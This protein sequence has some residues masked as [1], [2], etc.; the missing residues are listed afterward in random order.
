MRWEDFSVFDF[1]NQFI[2]V[3]VPDADNRPI[4]AF[5][6]KI[7]SDRLGKTRDEIVGQPAHEIFSGRAAYSVYRRQCGAW[8]NGVETDYEIALPLGTETMWARTN[9]V[10][11]HDANGQVTHMIG[12]TQDITD[13]RK[14]LQD[15]VLSAAA[16]QDLEDLMCMA[17]HDLRSPLS[18][19]KTL[20]GMMR[21]DF[22]DHGD[23]KSQL[24][25]M[26]D[27][28]SD[29]AL[30]VVSSIMGQAMAM[31]PVG[32]NAAFDLGAM[33]DDVMVMLDPISKH[34]VSYPRVEVQAEI[35]VVHIVLR[36]LI[37]NAVKHSGKEVVKI[38]IDMTPMNAER[39]LFRVSDNGSGF[40]SRVVDAW[41]TAESGNYGGFGLMGVRRLVRSRGGNVALTT[42][43]S[44]QGAEVQVE[45]PGRIVQTRA[46][47]IASLRAG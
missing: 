29:R 3:L 6:N 10:P 15:H 27:S 16:A 18:N 47:P 39:L 46:A 4:Y 7:G 40:D 43:T 21:K 2:F 13:E 38:S 35:M 32:C 33:C 34:S 31:G 9:L 8:A 41:E 19:L 20:A 45:L 17:A 26:I 42:P 37:D 25:D 22:V 24:I 44:G 11:V 30:S 5:L 1:V 14:Q 28:I 36:N 23:G 12:T